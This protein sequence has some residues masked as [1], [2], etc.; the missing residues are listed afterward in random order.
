MCIII[1]I[2]SDITS[3]CILIKFR[4]ES[5]T[6]VRITSDSRNQELKIV[7]ARE[8]FGPDYLSF[9]SANRKLSAYNPECDCGLS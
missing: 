5:E 2:N 7:M 6:S 3:D 9:T 4:E 8:M 1:D